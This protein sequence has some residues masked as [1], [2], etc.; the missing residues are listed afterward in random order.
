MS[1]RLRLWLGF[2]LLGALALA[3]VA[4]NLA[5]GRAIDGDARMIDLA[6]SQRMRSFMLATLAN[7]YLWSP[8]EAKRLEI[9]E[10]LERFERIRRG[11]LDGASELGLKGSDDPEVRNVLLRA[12]GLL[13]GYTGQIRAALEAA[14]G[15][16]DLERRRRLEEGL[17]LSAFNLHLQFDLVT[18]RLRELSQEAVVDYKR[19]QVVLLVIVLAV[20]AAALAG[21]ERYI[22]RPI[23]RLI[24]AFRQVAAGDLEAQ[25]E[26]PDR[27]EMAS[28]KTEFEHMT[29][30]LRRARS[31]L[32]SANQ[33]LRDVNR[34]KDEF[35]A[36]MSHE[37]RTPL[38]AVMGY[39]ALLL[40][41][42]DGPLQ[43]A[44]EESLRVVHQSASHLL[45][46]INGLLDLAKIE[47]GRMEVLAEEFDLVPLLHEVVQHL[48]PE[49]RGKPLQLELKLPGHPVPVYLDRLKLRQALLNI[50]GNAIKFTE[51]GVVEVRLLED[52]S[53]AQRLRIEI[54]DT[55]AGI[56]TEDLPK[57]FEDFRQLDGSATRKHGGTGLGLSISR[58][59]VR[60][61]SG[62]L[63]VESV[64]GRGSTF[65]FILPRRFTSAR[66]SM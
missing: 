18:A 32:E 31:A 23:P 63:E 13:S 26:L 45:Q 57:L 37:L 9:E 39:T 54:E 42:L 55:G 46:L 1:L 27:T 61:M 38:N 22:L 4:L 6:G 15:P 20:V 43:P 10:E 66:P 62:E 35:L 34:L 36:N 28:I 53:A 11:L 25:A 41:G 51:Q 59:L 5:H 33:R 16:L 58:K 14:R 52:E 17:I 48:R 60:L 19:Q 21:S 12:G 56:R 30:E 50:V 49:A 3:I 40:K 29:G 24:G 47:A 7:S 64:F 8:D 44:Q 65:R 2:L